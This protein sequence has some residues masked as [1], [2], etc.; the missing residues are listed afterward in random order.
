MLC[1]FTPFYSK[2]KMEMYHKIIKGNIK[3]PNFVSKTARSLIKS[4]LKIN[5]NKRMGRLY[6][7]DEIKEHKFFSDINWTEIISRNSDT[8]FKINIEK[9][10]ETKFFLDYNEDSKKFEFNDLTDEEQSYFS[11]F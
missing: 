7:I 3:F 11:D 2:D 6:G 8:P 9:K 4:L 1:G 5:P 10:N